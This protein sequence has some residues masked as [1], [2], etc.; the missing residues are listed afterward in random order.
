MGLGENAHKCHQS[1]KK[2]ASSLK[3]SA[4]YR[5]TRPGA[6]GGIRERTRE[7][8]D[9]YVATY[10]AVCVSKWGKGFWSDR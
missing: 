7:E 3:G 10:N 2:V 9:S 4:D 6:W 1:A 8:K 5:G